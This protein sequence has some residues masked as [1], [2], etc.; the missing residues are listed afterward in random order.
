MGLH[1]AS[2]VQEP[3]L[4]HSSVSSSVSHLS[5][6]A[7]FHLCVATRYST[8]FEYSTH[9][10][11]RNQAPAP[12]FDSEPRTRKCAQSSI[13][14]PTCTPLT[15][16]SPWATTERTFVCIQRPQPERERTLVSI[17]GERRK[18]I[19]DGVSVKKRRFQISC[20]WWPPF[21]QDV[22]TT[23]GKRASRTSMARSWTCYSRESDN[24][25]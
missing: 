18:R 15:Q 5:S 1:A 19:M 8:V 2:E 23:K 9:A 4:V 17:N 20:R 11:N 7:A 12:A 14:P 25:R 22:S 13:I 24:V 10:I 3:L 21:A 6:G 16:G